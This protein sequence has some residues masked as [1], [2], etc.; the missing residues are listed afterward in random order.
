ME[1]SLSCKRY[2]NEDF[3]TKNFKKALA[4]I[5]DLPIMRPIDTASGSQQGNAY[6]VET[7]K[8]PHQSIEK[9]GEE[10]SQQGVL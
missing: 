7:R 9:C 4:R 1:I 3:S 6:Q 2:S 10:V 8:L 5:R